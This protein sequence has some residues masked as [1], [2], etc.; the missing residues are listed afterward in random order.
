MPFIYFSQPV[1]YQGG[2]W[3][4]QLP[5]P[6]PK[7]PSFDKAEPNSQFRGKY[8]RNNL[9]RIRVSFIGKLSGPPD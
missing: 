6:P 2:I 8:I 7:F 4:A 9:I 3:G 5:P 1:A